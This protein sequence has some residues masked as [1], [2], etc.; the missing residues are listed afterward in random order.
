LLTSHLSCKSAN[1]SLTHKSAVYAFA[2]FDC[3]ASVRSSRARCADTRVLRCR[4]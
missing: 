3:C 2:Q 4:V 1:R